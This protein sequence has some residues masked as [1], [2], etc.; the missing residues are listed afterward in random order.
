MSSITAAEITAIL[1]RLDNGVRQGLQSGTIGDVMAAQDAELKQLFKV[2]KTLPASGKGPFQVN[3]F[4]WP[5]IV[6][7]RK[8]GKKAD[9]AFVQTQRK[10][11]QIF[12]KQAPQAPQAPHAPPPPPPPA[13]SAPVPPPATSAPAPPPP[14]WAPAPAQ[15]AQRKV[16]VEPYP[17]PRQKR[18][19]LITPAPPRSAPAP[20]K[21]KR[22]RPP[23]PKAKKTA[24]VSK[25]RP[26]G[27]TQERPVELSIAGT[28]ADEEDE[29]EV[30]RKGK[31]PG[32]FDSD[33][34][35][36]IDEEVEHEQE[37]AEQEEEEEGEEE[38][39]KLAQPRPKPTRSDKEMVPPCIR[40]TK[41]KRTCWQQLRGISACYDC[42]SQKLKCVRPEIGQDSS[43]P[44]PTR[45]QKENQ[46]SRRK[47]QKS[48]RVI[49]D[50][51]QDDPLGEASAP[52]GPTQGPSAPAR[53]TAMRPL[54]R[55]RL[56]KS[57]WDEYSE[58]YQNVVL[59]LRLAE[60]VENLE[61]TNALMAERMKAMEERIKELEENQAYFLPA[62]AHLETT[63]VELHE[64]MQLVS[65]HLGLQPRHTSVSREHS[66]MP[67]DPVLA[68]APA[69]LVSASAPSDDVMEAAPPAPA[70]SD[71][72]MEAAPPAPAPTNAME[73]TA[74]ADIPAPALTEAVNETQE[75]PALVS[76]DNT[77][78]ATAG[79]LEEPAP[80]QSVEVAAA[81]TSAGAPTPA[82]AVNL[83]PPTPQ[84]SQE[85][86]AYAMTVLVPFPSLQATRT[87]PQPSSTT[88]LSANSGAQTSPPRP[89]PDAGAG[90]DSQTLTANQ[91]TVPAMEIA[92]PSQTSS[93]HTSPLPAAPL[94]RSSRLS[95]AR[96]PSPGPKETSLKR[97]GDDPEPTDGGE[98][99]RVRLM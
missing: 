75:S 21:P 82:P 98:P 72:T 84:T 12:D 25:L 80:L 38:D 85:A 56:R 58:N 13:T 36:Q 88:D 53:E 96:I 52:T 2:E 30:V 67:E 91:L 8:A 22:S 62:A 4:L 68:P 92:P 70:P 69:A 5:F 74:A 6:A 44:A 41:L 48:K 27:R 31:G 43:A 47:S 76:P 14:T 60:R 34:Q 3:I 94:R 54:T 83:T 33:D 78:A 50:S 55:S 77:L 46:P 73:S 65:N 11:L 7:W 59:R 95:P 15:L 18:L 64:Q 32:K 17:H 23:A 35:M 20:T 86:G 19:R 71:D 45:P 81:A 42:G 16:T 89:T 39:M 24:G 90:A 9:D 10:A 49:T 28:D 26:K 66:P 37:Q 99:K 61:A 93:R 40:C 97:V 29:V 79:Q 51:E 1:T 87:I 57:K 63:I